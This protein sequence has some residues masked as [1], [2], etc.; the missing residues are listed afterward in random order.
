M[1]TIKG[2]IVGAVIVGAVGFALGYN[3]GRGAPLL[4][5][6]FTEYTLSDQ[7]RESADH[8]G[9]K[10]KEGVDKATESVKKALE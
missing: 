10:L 4:T 6:P 8:A 2:F 3:H 5:N 7:V 1:K 9:E